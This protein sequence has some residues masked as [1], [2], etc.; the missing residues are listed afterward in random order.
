[1]R[2]GEHTFVLC[3]RRRRRRQ[4]CFRLLENLKLNIRLPCTIEY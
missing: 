2:I 4:R 3:C 1:M